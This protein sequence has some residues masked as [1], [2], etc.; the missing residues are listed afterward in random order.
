MTLAL[1]SRFPLR[2]MTHVH[3]CPYSLARGHFIGKFQ[4]LLLGD[5]R[6]NA[7]LNDQLRPNLTGSRSILNPSTKTY[8]AIHP[9]NDSIPH[10][11]SPT[12]S[13]SRW[14]RNDQSNNFRQ[15]TLDLLL[16]EKWQLATPHLPE[17]GKTGS[18]E[19]RS[20]TKLNQSWANIFVTLK[21]I[22][23]PAVMFTSCHS[24]NHRLTLYRRPSQKAAHNWRGRRQRYGSLEC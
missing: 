21:M 11:K 19:E 10:L 13:P 16:P 8:T 5:S 24:A 20:P 18:K 6:V 1:E 22:E 17:K 9:L 14:N 4:G 3:I 2:L 12:G 23:S 7:Q 15:R